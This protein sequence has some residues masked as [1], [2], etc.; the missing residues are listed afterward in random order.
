[1]RLAH[2]DLLHRDPRL[3]RVQ[4]DVACNF[5]SMLCGPTGAARMF[6][7]QKGA[8]PSAVQELER[9]LAYFAFIVRRDL[10]I[11]VV[12]LP[13]GGAAG[14]LGAGLRAFLNAEL[15][16]RYEIIMRYIEIDEPIRRADLVITAEGCIDFSTSRGKIPCEVARRA[17]QF[18][19]PTVALVGMIGQGAETTIEKG[20]DAYSSVIDAPMQLFAAMKRAPELV[21]RALKP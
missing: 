2:I 12:A 5:N 19:V 16:H 4:I 14:G 9:A 3:D 8:T 20:L 1:M 6:G 18:G 17:K 13:G 11:D 10:G 15:H 21:K 7:P